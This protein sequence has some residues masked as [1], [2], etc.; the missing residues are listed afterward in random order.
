MVNYI[1]DIIFFGLNFYFVYCFMK[2]VIIMFVGLFDFI[3]FELKINYRLII[4]LYRNIYEL[5]IVL[6]Y[7][8]EFGDCFCYF[9]D[10]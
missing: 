1:W 8:L 5:F 7:S 2:F 10:I 9:V 4:I 6:V 3:V